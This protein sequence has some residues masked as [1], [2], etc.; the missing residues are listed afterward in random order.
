MWRTGGKGRG[1]A[2]ERSSSHRRVGGCYAPCC[3]RSASTP[4][5]TSGKKD[6]TPQRSFRPVQT[7]WK[8]LLKCCFLLLLLIFTPSLQIPE[9]FDIDSGNSEDC[10]MCPEYAKDIFDY[11][12][13]REVSQTKTLLPDSKRR[14][15]C[16]PWIWKDKLTG[17]ISIQRSSFCF[18]LVSL[19]C[20]CLQEKFVLCNYMPQQPSLNPEMRAILIDWL[21]EVQVSFQ[22]CEVG[23]V[24]HLL[25]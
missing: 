1:G 12:K 25:N 23:K 9:E 10:Y 4:S 19:L 7:I 11:L 8:S 3:P 14:L 13:K 2:E 6:F 17:K 21:V 18:Y 16:L 20:Y 5:E 15:N 24:I 22:R